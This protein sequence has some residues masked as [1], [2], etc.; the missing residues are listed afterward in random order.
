MKPFLTSLLLTL[1]IAC[2]AQYDNIDVPEVNSVNTYEHLDKIIP[3]YFK[4]N[5]KEQVVFASETTDYQELTQLEPV[6]SDIYYNKVN[7]NR[8]PFLQLNPELIIPR[9]MKMKYVDQIILELQKMKEHYAIF[10]AKTKTQSRTEA[11]NTKGLLIIIED[12]NTDLVSG[13]QNV[14][15]K[16]LIQKAYSKLERIKEEKLKAEGKKIA[17]LPSMPPP[18][19]PP[20]PLPTCEEEEFRYNYPLSYSPK[21]DE[22]DDELDIKRIHFNADGSIDLG[23]TGKGYNFELVIQLLLPYKIN[24]KSFFIIDYDPDAQ[25]QNYLETIIF[26]KALVLHQRQKYCDE[27]N[28]GNLR[29][30]EFNKSMEVDYKVPHNV[31]HKYLHYN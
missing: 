15:S 10:S 11:V 16:N 14:A 9:T 19:P 4:L 24:H 17:R 20:P 23:T 6:L 29:E 2:F 31:I 7:E 13:I 22:L 27:N 26:L 1:T 8:F 30:L 25:Y 12:L 28:L 3:L 5:D 18:P 21:F